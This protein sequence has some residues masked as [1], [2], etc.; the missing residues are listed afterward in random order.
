MAM[1][2]TITKLDR[3]L[4]RNCLRCPVCKR[5]RKYQAGFFY[6]LVRKVESWICPQCRAYKK[7]YGRQSHEPLEKTES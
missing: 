2:P 5:A 6:W 3:I 4:A 7:V 1:T